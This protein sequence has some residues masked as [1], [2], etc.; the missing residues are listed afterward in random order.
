MLIGVQYLVGLTTLMGGYGWF[1]YH[2]REVSYRSAMNFT[3]SRRQSQLYN[4]KGFDLRKWEQFVDEANALR[5]EIKAVANEYDVE[6]DE[7]Q[8]EKDEKVA[9]ALREE[10]KKKK[11]GKK[12]DDQDDHDGDDKK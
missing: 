4:Q 9:E 11:K 12:E 2:N 1:L 8:D 5:R 7:L 6:W 10:R 3:I